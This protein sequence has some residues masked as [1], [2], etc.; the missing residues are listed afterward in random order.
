AGWNAPINI[1]SSSTIYTTSGSTSIKG[2]TFTPQQV[3]NAPE[4]TPPPVLVAQNGATVLSA[5]VTLTNLPEVSSWRSAI[6]PITVNGSALPPAAYDTTQA[7]KIVLFPAQ[8]ALLQTSGAKAIAITATGFS[9]NTVTQ[10]L[11]SGP[12]AQLVITTQPK[13]P[14]YSGSLLTNQP[15]IVV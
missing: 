8:S 5:S 11:A 9:T 14:A 7:G 1:V 13:A 12:A 6:T 4:L 2:L 10:N 3:T 15:V